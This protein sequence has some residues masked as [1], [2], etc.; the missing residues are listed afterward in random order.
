MKY[1][2]ALC[3]SFLLAVCAVSVFPTVSESEIYDDVLRFHVVAKSD[4]EEDQRLKLTVR[5]SSLKYISE[6]LDGC[7]W[8]DEA[9]AVLEDCLDEIKETAE[10]CVSD[11]GH[12][13]NVEV[14]LGKE[15]YPR[16]IYGDAVMPKGEYTSLRIVI[17]EGEGHNWWCVLFPTLCT[18]F[19]Y[20]DDSVPVGFTSAEYKLITENGRYRVK[21]RVLEILENLFENAT[22]K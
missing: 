22:K 10:K 2:A 14:Y 4:S 11:N 19:S 6:K 7:T 8:V 3:A 12:S 5:D 21:L 20:A 15:K 1:I 17:G 9:C 18:G 16:R 13:D